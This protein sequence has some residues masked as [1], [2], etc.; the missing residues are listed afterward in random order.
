M[1]K[2]TLQSNLDVV[3]CTYNNATM[4]DGV[5]A[6]LARQQS[7]GDARWTCLV[8]NNN[9]TDHT[10]EVVRKGRPRQGGAIA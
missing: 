6:T 2:S 4:L 7:V 1:S 5:L 8:V 10:E 3:I 9:C